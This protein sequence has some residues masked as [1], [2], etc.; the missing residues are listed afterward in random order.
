VYTDWSNFAG[1]KDPP[2]SGGFG[3]GLRLKI[4]FR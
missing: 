4:E 2:P 1:Q 3:A